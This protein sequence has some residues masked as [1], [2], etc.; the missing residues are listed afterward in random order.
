VVTG[1]VVVSAVAFA[2]INIGVDG[3]YRVVDP[4]LR[5]SAR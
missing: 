5:E 2:V 3:L 4:R 1:I